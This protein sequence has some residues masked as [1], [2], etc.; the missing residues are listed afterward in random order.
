[1]P[2]TLY[3]VSACLAGT[4]CRYNGTSHAC[5][6][7]MALVAQGRAVPLCPEV[8]GGLSVPRLPC[9]LHNGRVMD[10]MGGDHTQ[11]FVQGAEV[12]VQHALHCGATAAILKSRSPSC[13][14]G[15]VYDGTFSKRLVAGNGLWAAGLLQAGLRVYSEEALPPDEGPDEP[16]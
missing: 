4:P 6:Q 9:E 11:A 8:L 10:S 5:P 12:A 3:V 16:V 13:G 2:H 15:K 7:V 14:W 1:M